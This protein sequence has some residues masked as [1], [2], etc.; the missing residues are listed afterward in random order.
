MNIKINQKRA[1]CNIHDDILSLCDDLYKIKIQDYH[2][3]EDG[4]INHADF[5]YDMDRLISQ[6]ISLTKDAKERG[7]AMEERLTEYRSAIEILGFI[8]DKDNK[9]KNEIDRMKEK[10]FELENTK[11]ENDK[12]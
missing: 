9:L 3:Y 4:I 12:H 7:C 6:I 2:K 11:V 10:I 8:R 1:I 5:E